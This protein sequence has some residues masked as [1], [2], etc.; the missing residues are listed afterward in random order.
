MVKGRG[1]DV[2]R[3]VSVPEEVEAPVA[4]GQKLGEVTFALDGQ[5]LASRSVTAGSAVPKMNFRTALGLLLEA[6]FR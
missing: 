5:M 1:A 6:L 4:A 3:T 2:T